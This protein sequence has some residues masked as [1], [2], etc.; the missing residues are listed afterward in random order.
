MAQQRCTATPSDESAER[1]YKN[2]GEECVVE[3]VEKLN[4]ANFVFNYIATT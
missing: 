1:P 2:A 3:A 4:R